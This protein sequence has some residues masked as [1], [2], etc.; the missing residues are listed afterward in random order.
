MITPWSMKFEPGE[1]AKVFSRQATN[2]NSSN[3]SITVRFVDIRYLSRPEC[4]ILHIKALK[5]TLEVSA[6]Q[7]HR[8]FRDN[9][10]L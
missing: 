9:L 10:K 2:V 1:I 6:V 4:V 5:K 8:R 3:N 7:L